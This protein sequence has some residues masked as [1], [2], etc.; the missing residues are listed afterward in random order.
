VYILLR[1]LLAVFLPAQR[2][3]VAMVRIVLANTAKE[4][5]R[6]M[7]VLRIGFKSKMPLDR[8]RWEAIRVSYQ[9]F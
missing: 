6:I 7:A 8:S 5:A 9:L 3:F 4:R 2:P 1:I